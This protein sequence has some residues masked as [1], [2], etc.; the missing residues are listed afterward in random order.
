[1]NRSRHLGS[2]ERSVMNHLW[3]VDEPQTVRAVHDAL[4]MQRVLAYTTVMT[5]LRRLAAKDLVVQIRDDRAHRYLAAG[6]RDELVAALMIDALDQI[7]DESDRHAALVHF[8]AQVSIE[9]MRAL[10]HALTLA[11]RRPA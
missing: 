7:D 10:R 6:S 5:V 1:M 8:V 2:L 9:E 11:E 3:A 4:C